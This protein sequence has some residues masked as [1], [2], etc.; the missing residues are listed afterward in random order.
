MKKNCMLLIPPEVDKM[1]LAIGFGIKV[2]T[3]GYF[4]RFITANDFMAQCKITD[5]RNILKKNFSV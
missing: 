3:K 5:R 1:H 2:L 4:V